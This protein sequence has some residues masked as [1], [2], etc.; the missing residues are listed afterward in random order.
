MCFTAGR[1]SDRIKGL[2]DKLKMLETKTWQEIFFMHIL[3]FKPVDK[4]SLTVKIPENITDDVKILYFK[5]FG[6]QNA[7]R[8]F[9]Y[10]DRH[11]FKFLWFDKNH[12]IYPCL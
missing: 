12:E 3:D 4:G 5:P 9:G 2:I 10:K 8:V 1:I 7:H 6:S 11:N